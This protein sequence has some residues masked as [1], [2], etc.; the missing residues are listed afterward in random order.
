[1]EGDTS[2]DWMVGV[3]VR[4]YFGLAAIYIY[5]YIHEDVYRRVSRFHAGSSD[6]SPAPKATCTSRRITLLCR[7]Y[8]HLVLSGI[9]A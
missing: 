7:G 1:M 2:R 8:N 3:D 5:I 4:T 6:G 9:G